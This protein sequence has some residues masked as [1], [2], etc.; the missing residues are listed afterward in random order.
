VYAGDRQA[1]GFNAVLLMSVQPDM[2]ARGPHDRTA[3]EGF[4][5]GFEGVVTGPRSLE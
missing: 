4:D 3:G 1:K 2:R 5:V